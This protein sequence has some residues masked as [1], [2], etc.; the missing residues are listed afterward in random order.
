[1]S[2]KIPARSYAVGHAVQRHAAARQILR[3]GELLAVRAM[4]ST[5][6]SVTFW[7]EAARSISRWVIALSGVR[8]GPPNR[9]RIRSSHGQARA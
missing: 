8:G 9:A 3:A 5:T 6:S 4:R 1:M 7:I 2:S